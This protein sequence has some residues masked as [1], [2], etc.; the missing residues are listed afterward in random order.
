MDI[1]PSHS[2][3]SSATDTLRYFQFYTRCLG[4]RRGGGRG[5]AVSELKAIPAEL[6]SNFFGETAIMALAVFKCRARG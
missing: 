2:R 5:V 4:V 6:M 3:V 1:S